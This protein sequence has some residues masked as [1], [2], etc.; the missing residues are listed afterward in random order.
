MVFLE[1]HRA[2]ASVLECGLISR[3]INANERT[4]CSHARL[5]LVIRDEVATGNHL[6]FSETFRDPTMD[7]F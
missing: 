6:P 2:F 1:N 7:R 3:T 5:L 4:V